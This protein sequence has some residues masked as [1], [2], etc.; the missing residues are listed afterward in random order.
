MKN[1]LYYRIIFMSLQIHYVKHHLE[2][3]FSRNQKLLSVKRER[4][5]HAI[6]ET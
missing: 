1:S 4:S 5:F 2:K 6:K 3:S